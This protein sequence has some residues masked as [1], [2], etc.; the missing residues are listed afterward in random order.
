[1]A[2]PSPG[3]ELGQRD[4][5][6]LSADLT[7]GVLHRVHV[8]VRPAH[9]SAFSTEALTV[10]RPVLPLL[11]GAQRARSRTC[12]AAGAAVDVRG[13][14]LAGQL[15]EGQLPDDHA[16]ATT[17]RDRRSERPPRPRDLA[18]RPRAFLTRAQCRLDRRNDRDL[19]ANLTGGVRRCVDVHIGAVVL[20]RV[21]HGRIDR[22]GA[23]NTARAWRTQRNAHRARGTARRNVDVRG[24]GIPLRLLKSSRQDSVPPV[25]DFVSVPV[26]VPRA[27]LTSPLPRPRSRPYPRRD[28]DRRCLAPCGCPAHRGQAD[29]SAT[30]PASKWNLGVPSSSRR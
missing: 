19:V 24:D 16:R 20:D 6:E 22:C 25:P 12:L 8:D 2:G 27:P 18:L 3:P 15:R 29:A 9:S 7:R 23:R 10:A 26:N 5:R 21:E 11:H 14:R 4:C 17:P 1:M 13:H 30:A 28:L